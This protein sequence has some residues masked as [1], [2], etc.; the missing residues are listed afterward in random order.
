MGPGKKER[1]KV[2]SW[3]LVYRVIQGNRN[4]QLE[5]KNGFGKFL[6]VYFRNLMA[7]I[8]GSFLRFIETGFRNWL[9]ARRE[10]A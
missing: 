8:W 1:K 4:W 7:G 3:C 10:T 6:P 9:T 2:N 5:T